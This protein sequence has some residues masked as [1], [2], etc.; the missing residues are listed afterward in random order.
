MKCKDQKELVTFGIFCNGYDIELY[1][2]AFDHK[3]EQPYQLYKIQTLTA[4]SSLRT[5]T[6]MEETLEN[7]KSFKLRKYLT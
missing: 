2:M 5:Y 3:A 4:P 1:T 7:L 6:N